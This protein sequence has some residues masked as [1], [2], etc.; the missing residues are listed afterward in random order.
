M[1]KD[2]IIAVALVL[3]AV[4][5]RLVTHEWNFT[6]MGASALVAGLLI[7]TR[8]LALTVPLTALLISDAVIGFH[9]T[10]W[11]VYAGYLVMVF[12][13]LALAQETT[14][15]KIFGSVI[16]GS[17]GFFLISNFGVWVSGQLYP[18]TL[19]GLVTSYQMAIPFFRNEI[20]SNVLLT[21]VL[22][23]V[24]FYAVVRLPLAKMS[25]RV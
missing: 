3:V 9:S 20:L 19:T 15:K 1:K 5:S 11:A 16:F 17:I 10:M 13:G 8:M 14:T 24:M 7:R 23:F 18:M 6:A 21:P 25:Y 2:L 12:C 22:F 4:F